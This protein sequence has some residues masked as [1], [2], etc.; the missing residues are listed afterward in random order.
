MKFEINPAVKS[1]EW[2]EYVFN[3]P[4]GTLYHLPL[5]Q[6]ILKRSF[7]HNP[8]YIF[9]LDEKNRIRGILP[10]FQLKSIF[11][12]NR[13]ISLPFSSAG[14]VA[15]SRG[16]ET[17]LIDVAKELSDKLKCRYLEVRMDREVDL[18][19]ASNSYFH[20]YIL[21]LT[22]PQK[23]WKNLGGD[24]RR[25]ITRAEKEGVTVRKTAE[26]RDI[27]YFYEANLK[28][29]K[30]LGV[31]GHPLA[32][33]KNVFF[34]ADKFTTL[35]IAEVLG[36][37]IAGI[38]CYNFKDT[39]VYANAASDNRW[40]KYNPNKLLIWKS[41]LDN[42]NKGYRYFNF[43]RTSPDD[44]GLNYFKKRW[45]TFQK[46]LYYY[47]YPEVPNLIST[48][49]KGKKYR[50]AT[51]LWSKIPLPIVRVLSSMAYMHLD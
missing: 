42:C 43:G 10:L 9:A 30:G 24:M 38:I 7:N 34:E 17:G 51:G 32:F 37:P 14:P 50:L 40:L 35:Y 3:H 16:I 29:K 46:K 22:D 15:D 6:V 41:I 49:R 44:E 31:P 45:G 2:L 28:A 23:I 47:Y 25:S 5:W 21:E 1:D 11:T 4:Q 18:K 27:K 33:L 12:G 26:L 36:K 20:T 48:N 8:Q 19:L 39:I 13:L